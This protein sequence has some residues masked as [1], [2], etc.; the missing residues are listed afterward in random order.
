MDCTTT[1]APPPTMIRPTFTP[2]VFLREIWEVFPVEFCRAAPLP[3]AAPA[4]DMRT[5]G[6]PDFIFSAIGEYLLYRGR[7]YACL[8]SMKLRRL[9]IQLNTKPSAHW[10]WARKTRFKFQK[11]LQLDVDYVCDMPV[12]LID[13]HNVSAKYVIV[14]V[15]RRWR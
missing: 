2:K 7:A 1:G 6:V 13:Q 4:S 5:S 8:Q 10:R 12:P 11:T 15:W 9:C 3:A 14:K